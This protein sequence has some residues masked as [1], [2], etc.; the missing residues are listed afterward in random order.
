MTSR[1]AS[2]DGSLPMWSFYTREG[3]PA[4]GPRIG[5]DDSKPSKVEKRRAH[6]DRL[7]AFRNI[8]E[9]FMV[10]RRFGWLHSRVLKC[11]EEELT[12]WEQSLRDPKEN[13]GRGPFRRQFFPTK[14]DFSTQ[15]RRHLLQLITQQL[16][17]YGKQ[18][19]EVARDT[20][21]NIVTR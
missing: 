13:D 2:D 20:V 17:R 9:S 11:L 14:D 1:E 15:P 5:Q 10:Y 8:N 4:N 16:A 3:P 12:Q 7:D 6:T 19:Q 21:L 18:I